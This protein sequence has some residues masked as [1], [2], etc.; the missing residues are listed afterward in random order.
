M[1]LHSAIDARTA[2]ERGLAAANTALRLDSTLAEGYVA[3]GML[4]ASSWRFDDGVERLA[5]RGATRAA[6]IRS[7]CNGWASSG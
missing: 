4:R 6:A 2:R 3:R 5:A 1:P 7:R